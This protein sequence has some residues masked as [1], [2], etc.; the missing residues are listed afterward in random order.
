MTGNSRKG[1][2]EHMKTICN[3]WRIYILSV[4]MLVVCQVLASGDELDEQKGSGDLQDDREKVRKA[5][6]LHIGPAARMVGRWV[7]EMVLL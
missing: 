7:G 5:L 2:S 3:V 6:P 1:Q 4:A